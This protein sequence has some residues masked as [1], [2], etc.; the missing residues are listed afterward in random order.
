[1]TFTS[2]EQ[3]VTFDRQANGNDSAHPKTSFHNSHGNRLYL[4]PLYEIQSSTVW[5][6]HLMIYSNLKLKQK[7]SYF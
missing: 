6:L 7:R 2:K 1:M 3:N 4:L 5:L